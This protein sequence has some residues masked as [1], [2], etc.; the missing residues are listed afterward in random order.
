MEENNKNCTSRGWNIK[1][2]ESKHRKKPPIWPA[3]WIWLLVGVF[4]LFQG[5]F[6]L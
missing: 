5:L 2:K 4:I 1:Q 6:S 3:V